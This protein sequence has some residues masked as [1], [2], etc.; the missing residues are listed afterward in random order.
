M[1][2]DFKPENSGGNFLMQ[3]RRH[4]H[5]LPSLMDVNTASPAPPFQSLNEDQ[6]RKLPPWIRE[7]LEKMERDK[8]KKEEED[9]RKKRT[10]EKKRQQRL[11][12]EALSKND[13]TISKFDNSDNSDDSDAERVV[14]KEKTKVRKSRFEE[15]DAPR[16]V[17]DKEPPKKSKEELLHELSISLRKTMTAVLLEVTSEEMSEICEEMLMKEKGRKG[18]PQLKSMLSGYGSNS[19]SEDEDEELEKALK[20]KKSKFGRMENEIKENIERAEAKYKQRERKWLDA[21]KAISKE[22]STDRSLTS[23]SPSRN[24]RS[25]SRSPAFERKRTKSTSID[26]SEHKGKQS[27]SPKRSNKK[28]EREGSESSS[29]DRQRKRSK[30]NDGRRTKKRSKSPS[31]T[32]RSK[33]R[34][35]SRQRSK[36]KRRSRSRQ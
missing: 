29:P 26:M 27:S 17:L 8:R 11:E 19:E 1:H 18:K 7:G 6:R 14:E 30:S 25:K 24:D 31:K 10:E 32:K 36:S 35:R 22:S 13:P 9:E 33:H 28:R 3:N 21:D 23:K 20:K 4:E 16:L 12:R 5:H 2:Q 15:V 34:S